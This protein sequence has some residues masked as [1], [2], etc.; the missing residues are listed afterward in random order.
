M[1]NYIWENVVPTDHTHLSVL[2]AQL[3]WVFC[4]V[5]FKILGNFKWT[6]SEQELYNK[7]LQNIYL[8]IIIPNNITLLSDYAYCVFGQLENSKQFEKEKY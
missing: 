2:E 6:I 7:Q 3:G 5:K 1:I 4:F 8:L